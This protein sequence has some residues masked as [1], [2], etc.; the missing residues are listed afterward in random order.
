VN[1]EHTMHGDGAP[2]G[3]PALFGFIVTFVLSRVFVFLIM[4]GEMPNMY[5]FCTAPTFIIELRHFLMAAV[6]VTACSAGPSDARRK[7]RAAVWR[8]HGAHVR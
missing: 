7:S 3:A 2:A 4:A 1:T 8:G 6:C 5:S